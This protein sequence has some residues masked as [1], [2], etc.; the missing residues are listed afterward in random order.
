VP[1]NKPRPAGSNRAGAK[2]PTSGSSAPVKGSTK[3]AAKGA[4]K[5]STASRKGAPTSPRSTVASTP[6]AGSTESAKSAGSERTTV[7]PSTA[8]AAPLSGA[9]DARTRVLVEPASMSTPVVVSAVSAPVNVAVERPGKRVSLPANQPTALTEDVWAE[10]GA[11]IGELAAAL[12]LNDWTITLRRAPAP[13][14]ACAA[15][16]TPFGQRRADITVHPHF[17]TPHRVD[18]TTDAAAW[19]RHTLVHELLHLVVAT[20]QDSVTASTEAVL[21]AQAQK[22]LEATVAHQLEVVVDH[23]AD[24]MAPMLPLP[25]WARRKRS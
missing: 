22:V 13:D 16:V 1:T 3:G 2:A 9:S 19:Q 11:Y 23:L 10:L 8:H 17:M 5:G 18:G 7:L 15:T 6:G 20:M 12:R 14:E 4:A 21:K 24:V 25:W